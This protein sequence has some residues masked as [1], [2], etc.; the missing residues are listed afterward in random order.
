MVEKGGGSTP[1]KKTTVCLRSPRPIGSP[2]VAGVRR[3]DGE[4][5]GRKTITAYAEKQAYNGSG[6][7]F[8]TSKKKKIVESITPFR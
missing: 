1:N 3:R 2:V 6:G 8:I 7:Y 5:K 4:S